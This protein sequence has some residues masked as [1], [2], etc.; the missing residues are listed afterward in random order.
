MI[1]LKITSKK[2]TEKKLRKV[3]CEIKKKKKCLLEE[4]IPQVV[5]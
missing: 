1:P 2:K 3:A 4:S 5:E